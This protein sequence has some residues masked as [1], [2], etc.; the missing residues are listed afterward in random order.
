QN[1]D[2]DVFP[3]YLDND[4][5]NDDILTQNENPDPNNNHQPEDAQD[6]NGNSVPDYLE[7]AQA[8]DV[9]LALKVFLQGPLEADAA[10]STQTNGLMWDNLREHDLLP[11]NEPYTNMADFNHVGSG[12]QEVAATGVFD[13]TGNNAIVDWVFVELRSSSDVS[14]V[15]ATRAA[16][17]QRDGDVVD[18]DGTSALRF[19]DTQSGEYRIAV[20]HR[21]HLGAMKADSVRLGATPLSIDFT[22]MSDDAMFHN[23]SADPA[24]I[25]LGL[26][27]NGAL[28]KGYGAATQGKRAL[29]A[30]NAKL[31]VNSIEFISQQGGDNDRDKIYFDVSHA[32]DN[33]SGGVN[34]VYQAYSTSDTNLD[35][36]VRFQGGGLLDPQVG[37]VNLATHP[38]NTS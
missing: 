4:D 9:F 11:E 2:D 3:D 21:N 31:S 10:T 34:H 30:G 33:G 36:D 8:S 18:V 38:K 20:R 22:Q 37:F 29:W 24:Q 19:A 13:V 25:E 16:L 7:V 28:A 26:Y 1:S 12:G 15:V 5:D 35:G 14:E 6:A 17:L 32:P 27:H 23:A